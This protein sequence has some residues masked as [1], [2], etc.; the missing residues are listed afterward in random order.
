MEYVIIGLG[1]PNEYLNT[2]HNIGR[3]FLINLTK[4]QEV[5]WV[6]CGHYSI[7]IIPIGSHTVTCAISNGF[8]NNTGEDMKELLDKLV[9]EKLLVIHDDTAF[10]VGEV[11]LA[12]KKNDGGHNGIKSII[13]TL[14]TNNFTRLRI[15]IGKGDVLHE[16]VL[17]KFNK[18]ELDKITTAMCEKIPEAFSHLFDG[19]RNAAITICNKKS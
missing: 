16:H 17:E 7:A 2:R 12:H 19:N 11:K 1:N 6:N 13:D 9:V 5:K 18:N 3:D 15:G 4:E 8:M 14:K 10:E